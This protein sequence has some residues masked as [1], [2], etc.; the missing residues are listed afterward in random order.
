MVGPQTFLERGP[1]VKSRNLMWLL[2]S[3]LPEP[4]N[5]INI[6]KRGLSWRCRTLN[7]LCLYKGSCFLGYK[8]RWDKTGCVIHHPTIGKLSCWLRNG[9]LVVRESHALQ[10]IKDSEDQEKRKHLE[11]RLASGQLQENVRV[12]WKKHYPEVPDG[13]LQYMTG[14]FDGL[15]QGETLPWNRHVRRRI[16][17]SKALIIHLY[18]GPKDPFW[19][20]DWPEGVE[21]LT[22]DSREDPRQNLHDPA[23]WAYL[24]HLITTKR[25]LGI[26]GGPPCRSVSRLSHN[27]LD[28]PGPR[29]V[30][31]RG[32]ERFGLRNLRETETK[33]VNSDGALFLKQLAL[34]DLTK[35][36]GVNAE[37]RVGFLLECPEDPVT[38]DDIV[39]DRPSFWD[40]D[41][42]MEF[43]NAHQLDL[44]SFDQG[45]LGRPQKKELWDKE[46]QGWRRMSMNGLN[47][48]TASWWFL[49]GPGTQSAYQNF[50]GDSCRWV[51]VGCS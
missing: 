33:L 17:R 48:Q 19:K 13:V 14:Q 42:L 5:C 34:Y 25:I 10:L 3:W 20:K 18:S 50:P 15:L 8:I 46:V 6:D 23:V 24:V 9:C 37:S 43:R 44:I 40:W 1:P 51:W 35:E 29:P 30:R 12:W 39:P 16:E 2:L 27:E 49:V 36:A 22:V 28:Q 21:V 26:V 4:P 41:E 32:D 7:P 31:G 45:C 38:Y 11:P 47:K